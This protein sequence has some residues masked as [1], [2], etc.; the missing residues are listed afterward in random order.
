MYGIDS[1][2][3][4]STNMVG[5]DLSEGDMASVLANLKGALSEMDEEEDAQEHSLA[6]VS[7]LEKRLFSILQMGTNI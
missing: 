5:I 7:E 4:C 2:E 1:S 3:D 6:N